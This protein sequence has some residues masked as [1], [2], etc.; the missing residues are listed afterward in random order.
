MFFSRSVV[1]KCAVTYFIVIYYSYCKCGKTSREAFSS[2]LRCDAV[3]T[4][5]IPA[6]PLT[7]SAPLVMRK[8]PLSPQA[9]GPPSLG[10][11]HSN[12]I[13]QVRNWCLRW[14]AAGDK[15]IY[16]GDKGRPNGVYLER[17]RLEQFNVTPCKNNQVVC[18]HA[19]LEINDL[20]SIKTY[21]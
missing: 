17:L 6:I 3:G 19:F 8:P 18:L 1:K 12:V 5:R 20:Q 15:K 2:S 9:Q 13:F 14:N 10:G 7:E 11:P 4:C 21:Y 16:S